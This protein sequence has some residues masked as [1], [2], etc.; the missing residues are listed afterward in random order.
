MATAMNDSKTPCCGVTIVPGQQIYTCE[1]CG[2]DICTSCSS[3]DDS[4]IVCREGDCRAGGKI[5]VTLTGQEH[6]TVLAALRFYQEKGMGE[7]SNR[8]EAI[9]WIATNEG[10]VRSLDAAGIDALCEKINAA[11]KVKVVYRKQK[12]KRRR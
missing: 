5:A 7:S 12:S 2:A 9:H 10:K 1:T 11:P 6:A 8:S 4:K 3:D